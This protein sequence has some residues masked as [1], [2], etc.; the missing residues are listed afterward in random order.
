MEE[1]VPPQVADAF[2]SS[3]YDRAYKAAI[4]KFDAIHHLTKEIAPNDI[5][6]A[7]TA[8]D[9]TRIAK[10]GKKVAVAG[11]IS[12]KALGIAA[13]SVAEVKRIKRALGVSVDD[14]LVGA[15]ATGLGAP[16]ILAFDGSKAAMTNC[17]WSSR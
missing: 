2:E 1:A 8:D 17:S 5:E 3:G 7:L 13:L 9:V 14:V 16:E 15:V 6:L 10:T 12:E 11:N 4:A